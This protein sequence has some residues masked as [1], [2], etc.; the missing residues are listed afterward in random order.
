MES[1]PLRFLDNDVSRALCKQV[2]LSREEEVRKFHD[3]LYHNGKKLNKVSHKLIVRIY[4]K[5]LTKFMTM[6]TPTSCLSYLIH[7]FN[8]RAVNYSDEALDRYLDQ[9]AR[10]SRRARIMCAYGSVEYATELEKLVGR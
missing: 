5:R 8:I 6:R 9:H 7:Y 10:R 4:R 1:S 3:D 2:R